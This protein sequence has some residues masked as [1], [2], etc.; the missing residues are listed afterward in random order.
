[1][2]ATAETQF[3][4]CRCQHCNEPIEFE[5]DHAGE[6]VT[7]PHCTLDTLLFIPAP[8]S[9]APPKARIP[10]WR[11]LKIGIIT[12][13]VILGGFMAFGLLRFLQSL[14][15]EGVFGAAT[16]VIGMAIFLFLAVLIILWVLLPFIIY[17]GFRRLEKILLRIERKS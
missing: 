11:I 13:I 3:V 4:K 17:F 15:P 14:T 8:Q 2:N 5:A 6:T 7:C 1:M 9:A 10:W 12:A 16:G